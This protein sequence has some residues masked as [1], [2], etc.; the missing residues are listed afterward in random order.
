MASQPAELLSKM[1]VELDSVQVPSAAQ[2]LKSIQDT[3]NPLLFSGAVQDQKESLAMA[4]P[5]VDI[6]Q[7]QTFLNYIVSGCQDEAEAMLKVNKE[8]ALAAGNVTD[9]AKRTFRHITGFQ[10]A[11]WNLD[12]KMWTMILPYLPPEAA[13]EQAQGFKT[14]VWVKEHAE[15]ASWENL[16]YALHI[17]I[18][19]FSSWNWN[20][21]SKHWVDQVGDA[22]FK[23]PVHVL[24]EYINPGR[25]FDPC[26]QFDIA[27]SL[28][29]SI[30]DWLA[31][32]F[33]NGVFT[34]GLW[35]CLASNG[36]WHETLSWGTGS[37][38][39]RGLEGDRNAL[40]TL[41]STRLQ[42]RAQLEAELL[43]S[44]VNQ[45]LKPAN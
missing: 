18:E 37:C 12:W 21:R 20:Q 8:L 29:R 35:R 9:H 5:K 34:F 19:Q 27:Y 30:P 43:A 41:Y 26:P 14:G 40:L 23:L 16:T 6:E 42:Q 33:E 45:A 28:K 7:L 10:L 25:P 15:H 44:N 38:N 36:A 13:K 4:K 32:A 31:A 1:D 17:Y 3:V 39:V 11:V 22:Q 24:Q 2:D